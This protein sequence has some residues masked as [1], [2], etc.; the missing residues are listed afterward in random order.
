VTSIHLPHP[1]H[2][3]F[4]H[5]DARLSALEVQ[6]ASQGLTVDALRR[7]IEDLADVLKRAA[8]R[9]EAAERGV[10]LGRPPGSRGTAAHPSELAERDAAE[11]DFRG[12]SIPHVAEGQ[13]VLP[14]LRG[15]DEAILECIVESVISYLVSRN[16]PSVTVSVLD[17]EAHARAYQADLGR[18][19]PFMSSKHFARRVRMATR[20]L[21]AQN[22]RATSSRTTYGKI[23][24]KLEMLAADG[25]PIATQPAA[26]AALDAEPEAAQ[27]AE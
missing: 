6:T 21:L 27:A 3:G 15:T 1:T 5:I 10:R 23:F 12:G 2:P 25:N 13:Q 11:F 16:V 17:L 19:W 24:W 9:L 22:V 26:D 4:T 8:T 7:T 20:D 14:A 18:G